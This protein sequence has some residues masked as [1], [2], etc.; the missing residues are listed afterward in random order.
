MLND[1]SQKKE[2]ILSG[3]DSV[4]IVKYIAGIPGGRTIDTKD[5]REVVVEAGEVII[6]DADGNYGILPLA[7]GDTP[8]YRALAEGEKYVGLLYRTI[9]VNNPEASIMTAGVVNGKLLPVPLPSDF[10]N[11]MPNIMVIEDEI[12]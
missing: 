2:T 8:A 4:V 3:T 6:K 11:A 9:P 7:E 12:A 10:L 5:E 1:K